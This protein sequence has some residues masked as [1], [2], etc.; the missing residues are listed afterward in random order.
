MIYSAVAEARVPSLSVLTFIGG[1]ISD[2]LQIRKRETDITS[3]LREREW[4]CT[5]MDIVV[6][7]V[8]HDRQ[9]ILGAMETIRIS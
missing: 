1:I 9:V 7:K 3:H 8:L 4:E 2:S 6:L 5:Q